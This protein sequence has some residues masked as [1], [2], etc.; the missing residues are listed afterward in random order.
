M[1]SYPFTFLSSVRASLRSTQ[2]RVCLRHR[3]VE[4]IPARQLRLQ[5]GLD[6]ELSVRR[7][8]CVAKVLSNDPDARQLLV[9]FSRLKSVLAGNELERQVPRTRE[10]YWRGILKVIARQADGCELQRTGA[11]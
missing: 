9:E 5:A 6:D 2:I 7:A 8:R 3:A 4:R 1:N 11:R 10:D